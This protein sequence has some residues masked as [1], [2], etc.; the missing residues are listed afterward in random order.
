MKKVKLLLSVLIYD[1]ENKKN[2]FF[3][4]I[5]VDYFSL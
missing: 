3:G 1:D 2:N 5:I 4:F